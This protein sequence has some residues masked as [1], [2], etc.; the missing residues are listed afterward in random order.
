MQHQYAKSFNGIPLSVLDL[1]PIR[2]ES[3]A[4]ETFKESASLAKHVESLG[5]NRYWLAEHHNMPGIGS[6]ATSLLIG[7]IAGQTSHM[8]VGAGGI[9]LPNHATLVIAEQFGTL[10]SLYPGRID[11]GL[12]RAPGTD[13]ATAYALRRTLNA[14]PEEFP[15][16]VNELQDYFSKEPISRVE[17]IPGKGLDI[18]IWLLGSSDF[19][20]RLAAQKGLPF[21]FASHFAPAYT[22]PA[23]K[24]YRANY[25]PS[26]AFKKPHAMVG[27]NVIAADTMEEAE[28]LASS[29]YLQFLNMQ[30]GETKK[31]QAPIDNIE[32]VWSPMEKQGVLQSLDPRTTIVG[33]KETVRE[34]LLA[35]QKE[36]EADEMIIGSQIYHLKDRLRSYEIVADLFDE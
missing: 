29:H 25:T 2:E 14:G 26:D 18:P 27:V 30:R 9:M 31:L 36:T 12:G 7:H 10:E 6:S 13:Q 21:S 5:F 33:D 34:R 8:R 23:L 4:E 16:Q 22:I 20:A 28:Y 35:F 1:A 11:L 24:L 3:N 19:S 32:E 17:A 15:M